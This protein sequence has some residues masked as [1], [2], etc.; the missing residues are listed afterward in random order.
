MRSYPVKENPFGLAVSKI[1]RYRQI[2]ILLLYYKDIFLFQNIED[3]TY[4]FLEMSE[5]RTLSFIQSAQ[6]FCVNELH[7][8]TIKL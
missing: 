3:A 7:N 2:E 1:L 4:F 5:N 8:M 6:S